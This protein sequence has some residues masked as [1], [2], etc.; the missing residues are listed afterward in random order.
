MNTT[1][2][3]GNRSP[4]QFQL[5]NKRLPQLKVALCLMAV[6]GGRLAAAEAQTNAR[7]VM[8]GDDSFGQTNMPAGLS[9]VIAIAAG[10]YHSLA[11]LPEGTVVA[12]GAGEPGQQHSF[13]DQG[14]SAVPGNLNELTAIAG[15]GYHSLALTSNG[16]VVA[17]GAGKAGQTG[18][19]NYGQSAVPASLNGVAAIAA[20][21]CHSLALKSNRTVVAWGA[22]GSGQTNVPA[23]LGGVTAIAAGWGHSL[24]LKSDSTVVAWGDNSYSECVVPAGLS[25]VIAIAG[26]GSH[27]L[28]LKSDGTVIAW[29]YNASGQTNVPSGLSGVIAIA[30]GADHCLALKSDHTVVA[31]GAGGSGQTG[32]PSYG[33]STVPTNLDGIMAI[34]AGGDT[35]MA[36]IGRPRIESPPVNQTAT[37]GA[38]VEFQVEVSGATPLAYQWCFNATNLISGATNAVLQ[39]TNVQL[40]QSGSYSLVVTNGFGSATS[41]SATLLVTAMPVIVDPPANQKTLTAGT[42]GFSVV[43]EGTS[44]LAYQWFFGA[45][46]IP[47]A[48]DS[49]LQ[50]T[51]VQPWQ[52]GAYTVLV[53]NAYGVAT[54]APAELEVFPPGT[55]LSPSEADLRAA[56]AVGGT[57]TFACDG[58]I[59]LVSTITNVSDTRLDGSGH[60]VTIGGNKAVRVFYNDTNASLTVVNLT[61][62]NGASLGGSAILNLGGSVNLAGVTFLSNTANLYGNNDTLSPKASG[63]AIFNR[64]GTVNAANC[65]FVGNTAQTPYG[66]PGNEPLDAL[67][68]GGAIRNEGGQVNLRSCTFVGNQASGG[69]AFFPTPGDTG[70]GGAIHNSGTVTLDLCCFTG[71]SAAGGAG[72]GPSIDYAGGSGAEGSGGAIFNQGTLTADRTILS[73]NTATGGSGGRGSQGDPAYTLNG[74]PGGN[75]GGACGAAVC[76]LGS[77]WVTRSTFASNTVTAGA[78]GAGGS[79]GQYMDIGGNGD[80][81]GDGGSG[82]GGALF[83]GGAASLVNCTIAF[84]T[85]SGGGGGNGGQGTG[86]RGVWGNG[87]A[88]GNGGSG[89]GGVDGTC[90]LANCTVAS[91]RGN[92]GS[93]GAGGGAVVGVPGAPGTSGSAWGGTACG[94]MVNT[95]IA[96]NTPA[97]GD[98]FTDPKLGPLANNGGPTLTMALLPGSPAIDAGNT[99]LAPATD[100]RGFPRPAGLAADLGAFEYGSVMPTVAVSRSGATGLNILGSGNSGQTCRLLTSL[101]LLNWVPIATNT[102]GGDGTILFNVNCAPGGGCRFYRLVML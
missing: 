5:A 90:N 40:S 36:L 79:G 97:G 59:L 49:T 39:L 7:V 6:L 93:G 31:W 11:L 42:A 51:N 44:P 30:A 55:V 66:A 47:G 101:D 45:D 23:G 80:R 89:F 91:N 96:S 76:N 27:S 99:S 3:L 43:A 75:G 60:Q 69:A 95:L 53:N 73:G 50:L 20:G 56:L 26:G 98:S 54:S 82:L 22:N 19:P 61:I 77:L 58:T 67:V 85:G 83:N 24:A 68:Y 37:A 88:G 71:N 21:G 63:G 17:W 12:W 32:Y 100:Q 35:S 72:G 92:G 34:A 46:A 9:N 48:T 25:N 4:N 84:N 13:A 16:T 86:Y 1:E 28:A 41:S 14:Q 62:A 2:N 15:G 18:S 64:G 87:G 70:R 94:P 81:G 38:T 74:W 10:A 102:I 52:A 78:G 29:G 33:Q 8:W 65:S 57:V